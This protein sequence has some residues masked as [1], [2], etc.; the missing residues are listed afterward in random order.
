[1][2]SFLFIEDVVDGSSEVLIPPIQLQDKTYTS[3]SS[4]SIL[5]ERNRDITVKEE[6]EVQKKLSQAKAEIQTLIIEGQRLRVAN[7]QLQKDI[8]LHSERYAVRYLYKRFLV[9]TR[10]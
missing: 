6:A 2:D 10:V 4:T 8:D 1:L 5:K 9:R 7:Q 3:L